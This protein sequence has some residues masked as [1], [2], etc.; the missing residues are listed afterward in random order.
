[1]TLTRMEKYVREGKV[2]S[3]SNIFDKVSILRLF[4]TPSNVRIPFKF[5]RRQIPLDV[6]F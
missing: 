2:I 3:G 1:M 4:L 5:Q 6:S